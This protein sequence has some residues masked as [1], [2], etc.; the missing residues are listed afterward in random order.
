[1]LLP[2]IAL[3]IGVL[4]ALLLDSMPGIRSRRA[5]LMAIVAVFSAAAV[6]GVLSMGHTDRIWYG[7]LVLDRFS[8]FT[9]LVLLAVGIVITLAVLQ[10]L[11]STG[12]SGD[13]FLLINL[14][15]LGASVLASAGDLIVLFLGIELAIIPTWALVAF[16][17]QDR[18][19][20]EAALK[21]FLLSAFATGILL[22]GLSLVYGMSGTLRLPAAPAVP[23]SVLLMMGIGLVIVGFA[24]DL[25]AFPFHEWLPDAFQVSYPEVG[26]FLAVAP[27]LAAIVGLSRFLGG[28]PAQR[29]G[30]TLAVAVIATVTM[31]WGNIVAFWQGGLKRLL[32]YS[33][34]AH[35]GYALVGIAAGNGPGLR[36][37][38]L[39]YAAYASG[40]IGAFLV[41][42]VLARR[43]EDDSMGSFV[44][45]ARR[46]PSLAAAMTVFLLSLIGVPLFAGFWGKFAVFWGAVQGGKTWLAVLGVVNSAIALGYYGRIIQ[47]MYMEAEPAP[48]TGGAVAA[49]GRGGAP[50]S[51]GAEDVPAPGGPLPTPLTGQA[52]GIVAGG[53]APLGPASS[54]A[55]GVPVSLW[56]AV[57]LSVGF[58]LLFGIVPQLFFRALG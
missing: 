4:L 2:K 54:S 27:K 9:D 41:V 44:G 17:L 5:I 57:W 21:Y 20:F 24:F 53:G 49:A 38:V 33:A 10:T 13:F 6:S 8:S 58:T 47:R 16:R 22:Y 28:F 42:S 12:E 48:A 7:T 11:G 3:G 51:G 50:D 34:V 40:A 15:L 37:A 52:L 31:F 18:R 23:S 26:G 46:D 14:S 39:Y 32:A 55:Q 25:A 56:L 35:A 19:A 45:L 43:G 30:W 29:P 36:G 1:M